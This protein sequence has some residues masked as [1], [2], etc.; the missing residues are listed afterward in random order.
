MDV[1]QAALGLYNVI[2]AETDYDPIA[3][4]ELGNALRALGLTEVT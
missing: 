4:Y 2:E 3:W 1:V